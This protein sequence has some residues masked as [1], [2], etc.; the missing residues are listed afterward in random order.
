MLDY[1][2]R[3]FS[4]FAPPEDSLGITWQFLSVST[5]LEEEGE[6]AIHTKGIFYLKL[7]TVGENMVAC[8][9]SSGVQ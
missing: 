4:S 9:S 8:E 3:F 6:R 7:T 1:G 5:E 2:L